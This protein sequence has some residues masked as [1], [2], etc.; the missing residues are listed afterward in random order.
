MRIASPDRGAVGGLLQTS[1]EKTD[2]IFVAGHRGLLGSAIV[3]R[4]EIEG[5]RNLL[6][7]E[8]A[9]LD[10]ANEPAV[11][12]F[13]TREKPEF[14]ILAAAKVGGIKANKDFPVEFLLENVRMQNNVITTAHANGVS[15]LL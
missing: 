13:L 4:L 8:R 10:L 1:M 7:R 2:K 6:T 14:V 15:K 5:Y 9:D 12:A 11:A 3:R